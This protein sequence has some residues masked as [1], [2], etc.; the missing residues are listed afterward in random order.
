M[1]AAIMAHTGYWQIMWSR[2][3]NIPSSKMFIQTFEHLLPSKLV[4]A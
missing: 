2:F 3:S 1:M 4:N